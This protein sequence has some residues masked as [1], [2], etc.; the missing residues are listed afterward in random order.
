MAAKKTEVRLIA[1]IL[2]GPA[3]DTGE[4]AERI[5][6]ALDEKRAKDDTLYAVVTE[7]HGVVTMYGPFGTRNRADKVLG[8]LASP[9]PTPMKAAVRVLRTV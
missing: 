5:I 7:W 4:L 2:E 9:G 3:E 1:G 8:S 6:T